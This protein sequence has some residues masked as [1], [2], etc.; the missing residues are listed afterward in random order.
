MRV[1]KVLSSRGIGLKTRIEG[2]GHRVDGEA[3]NPDCVIV[4]KGK[5][6]GGAV[7]FG[8]G[9]WAERINEDSGYASTVLKAL[10]IKN[11]EVKGGVEVTVEAWFNGREVQ[12]VVYSITDYALMEGGKGPWTT[13]MGSVVWV[14]SIVDRLYEGTVGKLVQALE[15]VGYKGTINLGL[16]VNEKKVQ[17][18]SITAGIDWNVLP[19]VAEMYN[20][21]INDLFYSIA[22]GVNSKMRFK[23]S[24]GMGLVLGARP[25]PY[26]IGHDSGEKISGFNKHNLKHFWMDDIKAEG[27]GRLGMVTAR[28][29]EIDGWSQLRDAKRR[30]MRTLRHLIMPEVMYRRD[31][32][33]K[34]ESERAKLKKWA[35]TG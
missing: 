24:L 12:G 17:V 7:T 20:G 31:I 11:G 30:I 23:S 8:G 25:F 6:E 13:G 5:Y 18:V 29:D 35:W 2:E 1:F 26:G 9:A 14:G 27:S 34:V 19:I 32:G 33:D 10:G 4:D 22:S 28:G 15:K 16:M 21:R 3:P